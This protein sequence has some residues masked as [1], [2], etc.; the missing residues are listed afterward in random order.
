MRFST[1]LATLTLAAALS[2]SAHF[3]W[4]ETDKAVVKAGETVKVKVGY[5]H[6]VGDSESAVSLDNLQL[7]AISPSGAKAA[8]KPSVADKW[9]VADFTAKESGTYR[10]VMTQDRGVMSQTTK[11][12]KAGGRDLHPD[13]KKSMKLWRSAV[14]YTSTDAA[15]ADAGSAAG[16]PFEVI[17]ARKGDNVEMTVYREGKPFPGAEVSLNVPGSEDANKIGDTDGNGR[18]VHKVSGAGPKLFLI[19][20]AEPAPKGANYDTFNLTSVLVVQ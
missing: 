4:L 6:E 12:Y 14:T 11:G 2:A 13:A 18:F 1:K 8:L 7:W 15:K 16:L 9:V 17:A 3:A 19:T 5:G 20:T 10:F